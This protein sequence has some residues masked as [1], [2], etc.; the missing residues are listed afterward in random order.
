MDSYKAGAIRASYLVS[1]ALVNAVSTPST[2]HTVTSPAT[3]SAAVTRSVC[4]RSRTA[5]VAGYSTSPARPLAVLAQG[6]QDSTRSWV[7]SALN[8]VVT[9]RWCRRRTSARPVARSPSTPTWPPQPTRMSNRCKRTTGRTPSQSRSRTG[10][11]L[12]DAA[13]AHRHSGSPR[14]SMTSHLVWVP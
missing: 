14:Y 6:V 5:N 7:A 2:S 1:R 9:T 11:R 10:Q 12:A 8:P 3:A 4:A 13:L